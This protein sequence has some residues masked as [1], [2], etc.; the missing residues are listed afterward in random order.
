MS[1]AEIA[2]VNRLFEEAAR[3]HD[4]ARLASLYTP[5]AVVMPPDGP[6]VRGHDDIREMWAGAIKQLGLIDVK[7]DTR[8]L[9]VVGDTAYETG[10]ATLELEP[11]R[12][13][14]ATAVVKFVVV[15]KRIGGEWRLHRDI[16]NAKAA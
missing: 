5:D 2:A 3:K 9:E 4:A 8:D 14:R 13:R 16:W 7:L 1:R 12:G 15:W 11:E 6:F 10:E